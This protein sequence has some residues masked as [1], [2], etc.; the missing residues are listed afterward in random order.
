MER[1]I[2]RLAVDPY[3]IPH[4]QLALDYA[5]ETASR[6]GAGRFQFEV[7]RS[8]AIHEAEP[9]YKVWGRL[10]EISSPTLLVWGERDYFPL[11][12]AKQAAREMP[13]ARLEVLPETGHLSYLEDP[14]GFNE[15]LGA[16]IQATYE[17]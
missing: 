9:S 13:A 8:V 11:S 6:P 3:R 16:W 2:R 10:H 15:V 7:Y 5:L 14:Q 4:G 17:K 1:T 12:Y